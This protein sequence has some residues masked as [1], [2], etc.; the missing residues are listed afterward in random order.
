MK[1]AICFLWLIFIL[2]SCAK[3]ETE[4]VASTS[5]KV[6]QTQ[7][8]NVV[9]S[10]DKIK[11][12][13]DRQENYSRYYDEF[14]GE[15]IPSDDYGTVMPFIGRFAEGKEGNYSYKEERVG[16]CTADG[17]IICDAVYDFRGALSTDNYV[18][19]LMG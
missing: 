15:F 13:E 8:G 19:Y 10:V 5:Q 6:T 17:K 7:T 1:R 18:Y 16:F 4:Q 12:L 14:V 9:F 3:A 2:C 11:E